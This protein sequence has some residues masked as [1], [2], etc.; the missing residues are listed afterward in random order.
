MLG[1]AMATD[2]GA[3]AGT[4]LTGRASEALDAEVSTFNMASGISLLLK[5]RGATW[6]GAGKVSILNLQHRM[7]ADLAVSDEEQLTGVGATERETGI[8][9]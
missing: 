6:V 1:P 7:S 2:G 9:F 3:I 4:I 5:P 8:A